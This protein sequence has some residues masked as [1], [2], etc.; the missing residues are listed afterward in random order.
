M[1]G[2][3]ETMLQQVSQRTSKI[4]AHCSNQFI[5]TFIGDL[6]KAENRNSS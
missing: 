4:F 2:F 5:W 6:C 1:I 3:N